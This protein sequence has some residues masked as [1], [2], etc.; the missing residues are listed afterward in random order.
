MPVLYL[1]CVHAAG[2]VYLGYDYGIFSTDL[3][4]MFNS[5][6]DEDTVVSRTY[7]LNKVYKP[8]ISI[9]V[10]VKKKGKTY[11][12]TINKDYDQKKCTITF[13]TQKDLTST[14]ALR[15]KIVCKDK[16]VLKQETKLILSNWA[17]KVH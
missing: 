3:D 8:G 9:K 4:F 6:A 13:S 17:W 15:Y 5:W 14:A 11:I 1:Q 2:P 7:S 10:T 12:K 16:K